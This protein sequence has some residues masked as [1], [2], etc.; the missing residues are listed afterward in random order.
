[1][2]FVSVPKTACSTVRQLLK[3]AP[4][5][6][7]ITITA[8]HLP[9]SY[10]VDNGL[11][12]QSLASEHICSGIRNPWDRL[13]SGYF[14][15]KYHPRDGVAK[16]MRPFSSFQEF[17]EWV[18]AGN[19]PALV[20]ETRQGQWTSPQVSWYS[21][22]GIMLVDHLIRFEHLKADVALMFERLG[23]A[24][25]ELPHVNRG[26]QRNPNYRVYYTSR[27]ARDAGEYYKADCEL[28]GYTF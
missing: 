10:L 9:L 18:I 16:A 19:A 11:D 15:A 20:G 12:I 5:E 4:S 22:A 7:D 27:F 21:A 28:G 14:H 2:R 1:M 6:A 26:K 17:A 24:V 23:L 13:V 8:G 25:P 3:Q